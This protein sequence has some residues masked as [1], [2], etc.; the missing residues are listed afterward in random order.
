[1]ESEFPFASAGFRKIVLNYVFFRKLL[2]SSWTFNSTHV[3]RM[4]PKN[5]PKINL[6]AA[7][8]GRF[9]EK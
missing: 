3:E 1:M 8:E 4:L 7:N 2:L 9:W 6:L 5:Y